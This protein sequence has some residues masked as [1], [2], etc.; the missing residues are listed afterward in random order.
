MNDKTL[1][2]GL[3]W[4]STATPLEIEMSM[5]RKGG[6]FSKNG[7]TY[8][9]KLWHH[10]EEMRK[11]LWSH[12]DSHRWHMLCLQ[13]IRRPNSKITVLMGPGSSGKTHEAAWNYLCEYYCFPTETC[14]L[15]SSTDVRGLE[16]RVW[17]EIKMLHEMARSRFPQLPGNLTDSKHA[18]STDSLDDDS[19]RD[20]RR[21]IIGIPCV[22][23]G[24]FVGLGKYCILHSSP[25]DTP[26]GQRPIQ[27]IK[28][29]DFVF[30]AIGPR[31][32]TATSFR[33]AP[34]ALRVHLSNGRFIDC[35]PEHPFLTSS[36]WVNS[37]DLLPNTKL[38]SPHETMRCV[39]DKDFRSGA[40][41]ILFQKVP[42]LA[43]EENMQAVRFRIHPVRGACDFLH[44]LLWS[45][46][47]N[48]PAG[49]CGEDD[50][51]ERF[52]CH[53][54]EN[55]RW[56][57]GQQEGYAPEKDF[58]QGQ[59]VE[60][61]PKLDWISNLTNQGGGYG[62][63]SIS[64]C[65]MGAQSQ[66]GELLLQARRSISK[67]QAGRGDRRLVSQFRGS[68]NQ[69]RNPDEVFEEVRVD[70]VE[71]LKPGGSVPFS[72][73]CGGYP[74]Y[75]L[76][77]EGHPSYCVSG[78]V[79][80]N[81]G[82]KQRRMR[83][84]A[85][86]AQ[87]MGA[88]FLSAFSNLDKNE[89]FQAIVLGNPVDVLDPLGRAAEPIEGWTQYL[90]P[91]KTTAWDTR[92][93]NGRCVNLV[94]SDSPN[95][96]AG[97][98]APTKF[99]YLISREKIK[100][101]LSF[102]PKDSIE[103]YSQCIG[104]MKVGMLS[105][106]VITRDLCT[107]F[108]ALDDVIWD[109]DQEV[110]SVAGLD[111]A[112]D[113]DRCALTVAQM[114]KS[115]EGKM[116]LRISP[117]VIVPV[118]VKSSMIPEDQISEFCKSYCERINIPPENFGHDSTG[119]GSLG[120]SLARVWSSKCQPVEFGGQPSKKPVSVD[121][122]VNDET[123]GVRRLKRCDEHFSKWVSEAWY[124]VRMA[125]ESRQLKNLPEETMEEGCLR[126]FKMVKG[127]KIEIEAKREMKE[128]IGRS[129]DLFDSLAI[130]VEI[131]RRKGFQITKMALDNPKKKPKPSWLETHLS[132][133]ESLNKSKELQSF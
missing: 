73:S 79:V 40:K 25:I 23:S 86:E 43:V 66:G 107:A 129:P 60:I 37:V 72:K 105:D 47:E 78:V 20:L 21:G 101:T 41:K 46:M 128:R 74:V 118:S 26:N 69:G 61:S 29:G 42:A 67:H 111:S 52:R 14:V 83:L 130:A 34:E 33:H 22:Q 112:Y 90:S 65:N 35:T 4:P 114:G 75:N 7:K 81:C 3:S 8:G 115:V 62:F 127:N 50:G 17:G 119:R 82:I 1:K 71:I 104:T 31:R 96:D 85:D 56:Y 10:Y 48:G 49:N 51:I 36:G 106:R 38:F 133:L 68:Q 6:R 100:N 91:E 77:V 39:W 15:V 117:P 87:F 103:Y 109:G 28:V 110:V 102:F 70:R 131:A 30:S 11:I 123:T 45:E 89:D 97:E 53:R 58:R 2:Y 124:V 88:G 32:V 116:T 44:S 93:M 95:L 63:G 64:R 132:E 59:F 94:G 27:D 80:H 5:I 12:L 92:F 76:Q 9:E 98:D 54:P 99:K 13:E 19:V 18:I 55:Q 126:K 16:L 125:I 108:G 24:K 113:G 57:S 84:V 120:T 121:L 122:Y